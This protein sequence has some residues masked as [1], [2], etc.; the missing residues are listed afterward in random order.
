VV[1]ESYV[2]DPAV[3]SVPDIRVKFIVYAMGA[4]S[5]TGAPKA[6]ANKNAPI[7]LCCRII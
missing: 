2:N 1:A 4:A 3:G 5:A 6:A 7:Q